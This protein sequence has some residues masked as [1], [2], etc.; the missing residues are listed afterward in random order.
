[1]RFFLAVFVF[2]SIIGN[3]LADIFIVY[4]ESDLTFGTINVISFSGKPIKK[5]KISSY[6][7]KGIAIHFEEDLIFAVDGTKIIKLYLLDDEGNR[8]KSGNGELFL[9]PKVSY[10]ETVLIELKK[11]GIETRITPDEA[12]SLTVDTR[13]NK[14]YIGGRS[15]V[16]EMDFNGKNV[17]KIIGVNFGNSSATF[18]FNHLIFFGNKVFVEVYSSSK[19]GCSG[20]YETFINPGGMI[21]IT[22]AS[23]SLGKKDIYSMVSETTSNNIYFVENQYQILSL[24]PEKKLKDLAP[25]KKVRVLLSNF[26]LTG[27]PKALAVIGQKVFWSS[28]DNS[29]I[30]LGKM[31]KAK[32]FLPVKDISTVTRYTR[33]LQ[34][35]VFEII[36]GQSFA[37]ISNNFLV[38]ITSFVGAAINLS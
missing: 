8:K 33:T 17:R 36:S 30:F 35:A 13:N 18:Y 34:M 31:N 37:V 5:F 9:E 1:M 25:L 22:N 16:F 6:T 21:N 12:T 4:G 3:S 11:E 20:I 15:Y 14:L 19:E 7:I 10:F 2:I 38:F 32:N 23:L 26:D 29:K 24:K 28:S 27:K